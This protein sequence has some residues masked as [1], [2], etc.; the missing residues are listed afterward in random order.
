MTSCSSSVCLK[1]MALHPQLHQLSHYTGE[2]V[3]CCSL[4]TVKRTCRHSRRARTG[5]GHDRATF[6]AHLIYSPPLPQ[7]NFDFTSENWQQ[8][9]YTHTSCFVS[10]QKQTGSTKPSNAHRALV[11]SQSLYCEQN[12]SEITFNITRKRWLKI[13]IFFITSNFNNQIIN[14]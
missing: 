6:G 11:M 7:H 1:V 5:Q 8:D 9:I 13:Q 14:S 3:T 4:A 2:A 12:R 10:A